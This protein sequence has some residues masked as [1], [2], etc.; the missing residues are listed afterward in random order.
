V[1]R[2]GAG[3]QRLPYPEDTFDLAVSTRVLEYVPDVAAALA[4]VYRVLRPG[5]RLLVLDTSSWAGTG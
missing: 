5:G 1:R 2:Y 3:A 4:E